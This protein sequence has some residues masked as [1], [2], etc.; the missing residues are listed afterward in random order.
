VTW[1]CLKRYGVLFF[2]H[3]ALFAAA[4]DLFLFAGAV[5]EPV[6]ATSVGGAGDA[7]HLGSVVFYAGTVDVV[8]GSHTGVYGVKLFNSLP[9][10][11]GLSRDCRDQ[12]QN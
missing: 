5:G 8:R 7:G 12:N 1:W 2:N 10:L 4:G 6:V 3:G 11:C 9:D